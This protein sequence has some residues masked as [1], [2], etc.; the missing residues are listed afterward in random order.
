MARIS[1]LTEFIAEIMRI[2]G[3]WFPDDPHPEIWYRG[4]ISRAYALSPGAYWRK[5][6]EERSLVLS[7]RSMAPALLSQQPQSDWDWYFLMQHYGLPTRLLDW[8]ESPLSALYFALEYKPAKDQVPCVWVLDPLALNRLSGADAVI[9]P[10]ANHWVS[11][12]LPET[13]GRQQQAVGDLSEPPQS[14]IGRPAW[15]VHRTRHGRDRDRSVAHCG[16]RWHLRP[17]NGHRNR[18]GG[19]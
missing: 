7:F 19:A 5:N 17:K 11:A 2:R 15:H 6:C 1:S 12:W 18:S 10:R 9:V 16:R 14:A 3:E 8:S 4:V 13:C